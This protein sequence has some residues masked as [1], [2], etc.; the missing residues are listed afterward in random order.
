MLVESLSMQK[1][2]KPMEA[3][4]NQEE[5]MKEEEEIIYQAVSAIGVI[6]LRQPLIGME[7]NQSFGCLLIKFKINKRERVCYGW[8]VG[9]VF[10]NFEEKK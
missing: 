2:K 5:E 9:K 8:I 7:K 4:K 1:L 6:V 10:S 3:T